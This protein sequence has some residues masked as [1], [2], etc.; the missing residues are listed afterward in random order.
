MKV[1]KILKNLYPFL[2]S[3][4]L[5]ARLIGFRP[6]ATNRNRLNIMIAKIAKGRKNQFFHLA[7]IG[8]NVLRERL[9]Q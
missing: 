9:K 7:E 8:V 1:G 3:S 5:G 2:L 6:W 4:S